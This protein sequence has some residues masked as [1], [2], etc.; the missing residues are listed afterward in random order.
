LGVETIFF[1]PVHHELGPYFAG[2]GDIEHF[3]SELAVFAVNS[4]GDYVIKKRTK[5]FDGYIECACDE[6]RLVTSG[7]MCSYP[8]QTRREGFDENEIAKH[9]GCVAL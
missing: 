7:T 9:F 1:G 4:R 2:R 6:N 8:A 3:A 5:R